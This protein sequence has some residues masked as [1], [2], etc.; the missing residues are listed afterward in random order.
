MKNIPI[1]KI[2][3]MLN[4]YREKLIKA[5]TPPTDHYA[6]IRLSAQ[7]SLLEDLYYAAYLGVVRL[8][9]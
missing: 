5:E 2:E 1:D 8:G 4:L 9:G 3:I 6:C 7:I